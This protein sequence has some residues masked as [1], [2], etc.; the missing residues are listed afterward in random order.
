[1]DESLRPLHEKIKAYIAARLTTKLEAFDKE[2]GKSREFFSSEELGQLEEKQLCGRIQLQEKYEIK[3]WLTD[4]A[5]RAGQ[6]SMVTHAPKYTHSETKSM[7]VLVQESDKSIHIQSHQYL[8]STS[9][10][11]LFI[12]VVGNAAALDVA[13]LLLIEADGKTLLDEIGVGNSPALATIAESK[14]QLEEWIEGFSKAISNKELTSGQLSKQLYFPLTD[15]K[16][17]LISPLYASALGQAMYEK[18][19]DSFYSE[20]AKK[21]RKDRKSQ[22]FNP[23]IA[24]SYPNIAKQTFG[25]TKPQNI[26]QLNTNRYGQ[27]FLL[28]C[29]PPRWEKQLTPPSQTKNAFWREYDRRAWKTASF[30]QKYLD[31]IFTQSS[32][33]ERREFRAELVD[34]LV[35]ILLIYAAEVQNLK[36]HAGWSTDSKLSNAEQLWLDPHRGN[37]DTEFRDER[38]KN[39]WQVEIASQFATWLNYKISHKSAALYTDDDT[40]RFWKRLLEKKLMLLKEDLEVMV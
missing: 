37:D 11:N 30:L 10:A 32:T 24:V 5:K 18:M 26:S 4:A 36:G 2:G 25:G 34:D 9:L 22:K 33:I 13:S 35:D 17:H 27:G 31:K 29:Q 23:S 39:D 20:T 12:D 21:A 1:M 38:D 8:C 3:T 6:I 40:F 16:Y 28:S 14:D 15:G 19:T 7:G